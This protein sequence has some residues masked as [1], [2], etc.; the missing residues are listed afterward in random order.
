VRRLGWGLE[1]AQDLT[2]EFFARLLEKKYLKRA[3]PLRGRFRTFLLTSLGHFLANEWEKRHALKRGAG[4]TVPLIVMDAGEERYQHEP[5]DGLTPDRIYEHRWAATLLESVVRQL[6]EEYCALRKEELFES[7]KPFVWGETPK[8]GY[9]CLAGKLN[10]SEGALRVAVHRM[11]E[12][13]RTLLRETVAQTVAGPE[14]IEDE[15][16]HLVSVLRE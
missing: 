11:R 10:T 4:Q 3:D 1:D 6:R 2:Q 13:Y 16:R 15:L 12:R 8:D 14:D 9:Q 7:L 5:V